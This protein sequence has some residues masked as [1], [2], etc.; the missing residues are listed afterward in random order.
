MSTL[1]VPEGVHLT[2]DLTVLMATAMALGV[3]SLL[4]V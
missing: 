4:T 3:Y 2:T 1:P